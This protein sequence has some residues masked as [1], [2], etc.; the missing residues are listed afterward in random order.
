MTLGWWLLWGSGCAKLGGAGA[1]VPEDPSTWAACDG[2]HQTVSGTVSE[3]VANH[4]ISAG[5]GQVQLYLDVGQAQLVVLATS[6]PGCVGAMSATGELRVVD[7][8]GAPGTMGGYR[9]LVIDA[10]E[11][12]CR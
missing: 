12:S 5:P 6:D 1:C 3:Q 2:T 8:G 9:G 11:V 7:L 10:S 4:P